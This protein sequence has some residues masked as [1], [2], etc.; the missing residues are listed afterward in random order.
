M[1]QSDKKKIIIVGGCGH[2]GLPLAVSL[3]NAGYI[4]VV[5]DLNEAAIAIAKNGK[6]PFFEEDGDR[7]LKLALSTGRLQFLSQL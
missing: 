5:Y 6:M 2:I 1:E 3:A 7:Q 4:I